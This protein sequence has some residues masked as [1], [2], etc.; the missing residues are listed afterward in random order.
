MT[1]AVDKNTINAVK[2]NNEY[3]YLFDNEPLIIKETED[4]YIVFKAKSN[5]VKNELPKSVKAKTITFKDDGTI[6]VTVPKQILKVS[7]AINFEVVIVD[8]TNGNRKTSPNIIF[9]I[10]KS[11]LDFEDLVRGE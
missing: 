10:V 5:I 9:T 6:S 3:I 1:I 7:G 8:E 4:I 2:S 11:I